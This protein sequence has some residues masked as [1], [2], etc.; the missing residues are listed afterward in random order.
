MLR[1]IIYK[2]LLKTWRGWTALMFLNMAVIAYIAAET[3][4]MFVMDHPEIV[5]YRVMYLGSVHFGSLRSIPLLTGALL[6]AAQFLPEMRDERFRLSLHLPVELHKV[7][8]AHVAFGLFALGAILLTDMGI[9][10]VLT[11]SYFPLEAV[12]MSLWTAAPWCLAGFVAYLGTALALLEPK[13]HLKAALIAVAIA[14]SELY[15][16]RPSPGSYRT[17][18]STLAL[19]SALLVP[20]VLLSAYRFRFRRLS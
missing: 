8:T 14:L 7:V 13:Y 5:W 18:L 4:S 12:T 17:I 16:Y 1:S 3:R 6:G 9:L 2:E 11:A 20:G 10:A 15:M 19:F